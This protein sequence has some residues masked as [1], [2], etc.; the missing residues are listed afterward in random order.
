MEQPKFLDEYFEMLNNPNFGKKSAQTVRSYRKDLLKFMDYFKITDLSQL[1]SL[2]VSD[3][4]NFYVETKLSAN[5]LKGLIRNLNVYFNY[6]GKP[7]RDNEFFDVRFGNRKFPKVEVKEVNPP[8]DEEISKI[9]QS[10]RNK[11]ER[12]MFLMMAYQGFRRDEVRKIKLSDISGCHVHIVGK[13]NKKFDV[14]LHDSVCKALNEY[15]SEEYN[16]NDYLFVGERGEGCGNGCIT[17]NAVNN[18]VKSAMVRAGFSPERIKEIHAHSFRHTFVSE[19]IKQF[20]LETA[21]EAARHSSTS[22]TQIYNHTK[23]FVGNKAIEQ[24]Q[25]TLEF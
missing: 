17:G 5:S 14:R 2:T 20:G 16:G 10:A 7:F 15:L 19:M 23:E 13:G 11:Q 12:L 22:V 6:L 4:K 18:R 21:K 24:S 8:T 1:H 9:I 25:R 3:Y